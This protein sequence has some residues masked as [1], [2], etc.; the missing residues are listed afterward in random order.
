MLAI[1]KSVVMDGG[2]FASCRKFKNHS[3]SQIND[4][5][6]PLP[7]ISDGCTG[8]ATVNAASDTSGYGIGKLS[9]GVKCGMFFGNVPMVR[10]F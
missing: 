4:C 2:G 7:Q 6:L 3:I 5:P 8:R 1:Q 9:T 10:S